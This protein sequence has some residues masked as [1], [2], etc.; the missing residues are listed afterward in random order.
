MM[1]LPV[2]DVESTTT[3]AIGR[4]IVEEW[5]TGVVSDPTLV[6][7][8]LSHDV[9]WAF[10]QDACDEDWAGLTATRRELCSL[11]ADAFALAAAED[12][13][14]CVD[15]VQDAFAEPAPGGREIVV[16]EAASHELSTKAP[17]MRLVM[18]ELISRLWRQYGHSGEVTH[19]EFQEIMAVMDAERKL[20]QEQY[21]RIT[22]GAR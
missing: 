5:R 21:E 9:A 3:A 13:W 14:V 12:S 6:G 2:V 16:L 11:Q 15:D 18:D 20:K 4:N 17:V 22:E 8:V 19:L 10:A 1:V 7:R